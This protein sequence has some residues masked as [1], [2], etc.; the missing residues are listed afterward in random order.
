VANTG[1]GL[2][3]ERLTGIFTGGVSTRGEGRGLGLAIARG[4]AESLGGWVEVTHPGGNGAMTVFV[5][6]LPD[7]LERREVTA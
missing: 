1:D 5:S 4:T 2:P 3:P 6:R 7:V